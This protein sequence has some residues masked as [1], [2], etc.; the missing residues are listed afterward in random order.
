[1]DSFGLLNQPPNT[2]FI[3]L[4]YSSA[5]KFF[6]TWIKDLPEILKWLNN[7]GSFRLVAEISPHGVFHWH[8]II[9][10]RDSIKHS[11]FL[12][13]WRYHKG[14]IDMKPVRNL[15][16]SFTYIRKQSFDISSE[17]CTKMNIDHNSIFAIITNST[18]PLVLLAIKDYITK[19]KL[20]N[21]NI[22]KIN[23]LNVGIFKF[24]KQRDALGTA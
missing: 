4:T 17:I 24:Y 2:Y 16:G 15:L 23:D 1:M 3:T 18:A 7:A 12:N 9:G 13:H 14:H 5:Q 10:V 22:K 21:R 6:N 19:Q 11:K 20:S 8:Y